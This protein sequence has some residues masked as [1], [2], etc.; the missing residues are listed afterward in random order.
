MFDFFRHFPW[1]LKT[2]Y[3]HGVEE[4][5]SSLE[6]IIAGAENARTRLDVSSQLSQAPG[7]GNAPHE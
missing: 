7:Q 3:Y 6:E 1:V 2:Y 4:A 5:L